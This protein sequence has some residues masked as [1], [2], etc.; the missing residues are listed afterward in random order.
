MVDS[1]PIVVSVNLSPGGIPKR[2]VSAGRVGAAGLDGDGHA[3]EKHNSPLQAISIID[4]EDIDDL[5]REGFEVYPGATGENLTVRGMQVD[6]LAPG[7][8]LRFGGG[9]E[10][11]LTRRRKPCFVLDVIDPRLKE[12]IVGRCGFLAKVIVEGEV[13]AG[14][15]IEVVAAVAVAD[16]T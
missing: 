4:L 16:G 1:R 3:H 10:L 6:A 14:E 9:V 7:D 8:R 2:P 11:E 15:A 12:V 13:R 5:R